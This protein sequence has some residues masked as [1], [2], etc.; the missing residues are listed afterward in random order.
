MGKR[1]PRKGQ[2]KVEK[3]RNTLLVDGNAL[4][5]VGYHGAIHEVNWKGE[6]IGAIY[7]FI[8]ILRKLLTEDLYHKVYV[9]WDGKLSG[10]LRYD[11]YSDYKIKRGK[12]YLTGIRTTE[13]DKDFLSQQ[14]KLKK[15]LEELFIRQIEDPIVEGDDM[16]AYYTLNRPKDERIT[17][18]T[19]DGDISQLLGENVRIYNCQKKFYVTPENF[20]EH[21][22]YHV[23]NVKVVKMIIGDT[24]D[25][26]KGVKG[27]GEGTLLKHFP[28]LKERPM[29]L[30]EI[31]E[32]A[33]IQQA[34]R[35]EKKQ[36]PLQAIQNLIEGR[37]DGIQGSDL[38]KINEFIIDLKNPLLTQECIE[39]LDDYMIY[40]IDPDDRD[41]KN[42]YEF[43]KNQGLARL[44]GTNNLADYLLPFKKLMD[45]ELNYLETFN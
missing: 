10:R 9:F 14:I 32:L 1:P 26:I 20:Q 40:P 12:C 34:E 27:V 16:I 11:V 24:A 3:Y 38:F 25:D 33:K 29:E 35:I 45:R 21:Y 4:F 15:Y 18:V 2:V 39:M 31:I 41:I 36:K 23:D 28:E 19:N 43:I 17:I 6:K 44:I 7:Q 13:E 8:T 42:V 30:S 22:N 5:K 37:T